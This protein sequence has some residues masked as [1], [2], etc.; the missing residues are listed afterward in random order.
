M[1]YSEGMGMP[2]ARHGGVGNLL[3]SLSRVGF[4]IAIAATSVEYCVGQTS[5]LNPSQIPAVQPADSV[6]SSL[7]PPAV[8]DILRSIEIPA[9]QLERPVR[10]RFLFGGGPP[11]TA[12]LQEFWRVA[13]ANDARIVVIGWGSTVADEYYERFR[14]ALTTA[15]ADLGEESGLGRD[16]LT[17]SIEKMPELSELSEDA[18]SASS[19]LRNAT[20]VFF[21]GGDQVRLMQ[22]ITTTGVGEVVCELLDTGALVHAGTSAG[23]AIGSRAMIGGYGE[24]PQDVSH[25]LFTKISHERVNNDGQVEDRSFF[26]GEG[27]AIVPENVLIEQ[28]LS[29]DGRKQRFLH[30]V[31]SLPHIEWGL[32]VDDS[33]AALWSGEGRIKAI[34]P[35][36]VSIV[37][38][39]KDGSVKEAAWLRHGE[40]FDLSEG[41]VVE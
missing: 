30:A 10:P 4:G 38:K 27:L 23:T 20:A 6:F 28:H 39:Q 21:L 19:L 29:R 5:D 18:D 41:K 13:G 26:I 8:D 22:A 33:M 7:K 35:T 40:V 32:G 31:A 2:V 24:P 37:R 1:P 15:V 14:N 11:N 34:G 16:S 36:G 25:Q 3:S 9:P 17:V 12:A